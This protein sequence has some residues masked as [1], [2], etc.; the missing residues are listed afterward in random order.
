[1]LLC[2]NMPTSPTVS[3]IKHTV[4]KEKPTSSCVSERKKEFTPIMK[5]VGLLRTSRSFPGRM[6]T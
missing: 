3:S 1:M 6:G 5:G 2:V 4:Y